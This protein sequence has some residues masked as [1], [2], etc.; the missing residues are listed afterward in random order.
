MCAELVAKGC[1]LQQSPGCFRGVGLQ[2][3]WPG[4]RQR[5]VFLIQH[6]Q[7]FLSLLDLS[8][9]HVGLTFEV[10]QK[11]PHV[12]FCAGAKRY[13]WHRACKPLGPPDKPVGSG[14]GHALPQDG[15]PVFLPAILDSLDVFRH[16][17]LSGPPKNCRHIHATQNVNYS[18]IGPWSILITQIQANM[19][20]G[21]KS[22]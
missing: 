1:P 5:Q 9:L 12:R 3:P 18:I 11:S 13:T 19:L 7:R 22:R 6:P 20:L 16:T 17:C 2:G 15:R 21:V 4:P 10:A 8:R 14:R